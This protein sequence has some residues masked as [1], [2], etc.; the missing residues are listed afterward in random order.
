[1]LLPPARRAV[2]L[3]L[4]SLVGMLLA[5]LSGAAASSAVP[6][7]PD[8]APET[9]ISGLPGDRLTPAQPVVL[10]RRP[11]VELAASEP[12]TFH[13]AIN[14]RKVPCQ[15]GPNV[16]P[17][18]RPGTQVFVA[19]AVDAAGNFDATPA[20]TTFYVPL[21]L[22]AHQGKHWKKV[23]SRASFDG[24]YVSTTSQG[25]VLTLGKVAGVHELRLIAPTGP[26]LGKVAV[27][28]GRGGWLTVNLRS[29]KPHKLVSF[30]LRGP[31]A[32]AQRGAIQV[33]ALTVP[34]GG[35]V[36]VDAVVAR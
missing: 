36:A 31:D 13:C 32:A 10:T 3:A 19:Q 26:R 17:T 20:T 28:V 29:A 21:N 22:T 2:P 25:A 16:L 5:L 4:A 12:A 6:P 33:K 24:D 1:M 7:G 15:A 23:R 34:A 11:T 30:E 18:L 35:A 14:S 8:G 27:R 9:E